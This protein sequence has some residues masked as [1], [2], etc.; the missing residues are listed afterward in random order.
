MVVG[1]LFCS[2]GSSAVDLAGARALDGALLDA[3]VASQF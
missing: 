3:I 2:T 1:L